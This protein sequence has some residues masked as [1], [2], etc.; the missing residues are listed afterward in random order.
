MPLVKQ[1]CPKVAACWS[2]RDPAIGTPASSPCARALPY[3]SEL[4]TIRG[5][6]EVGM[7]ISAAMSSSQL[8]VR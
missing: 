6:I 3:T 1:T 2:P 8:R 4:D 5:S 7:P